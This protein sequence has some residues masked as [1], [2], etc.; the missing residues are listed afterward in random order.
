MS[1]EAEV[2]LRCWNFCKAF[3]C[4]DKIRTYCGWHS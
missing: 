1:G 3:Y 4:R 2:A